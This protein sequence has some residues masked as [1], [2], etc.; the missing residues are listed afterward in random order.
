MAIN[1]KVMGIININ[2]DSYFAQ[3]RAIGNDAFCSRAEMLIEQGVDIIDIGACSTRPGSSYID[4]KE[5]W[6]RLGPVLKQYKNK[7]YNTP[8][9][10]DTFRSEIVERVYDFL[11]PFIVN[12]ISAGEDDLKML[13]SVG[14]IGLNYIA[15]HKRGT[16]NTM[17]GLCDYEDVVTDIIKYFKNFEKKAEDNGV[18][19][20]IIDPGFG[21]AKTVDQN[22]Q[23]L[24]RLSEFKVL[25]REILVGISRKSMI[26]CLLGITPEEA[27]PA[28]SALHLQALLSGA[29]ILRVHDVKEA[30]QS[31]A[32]FDRISYFCRG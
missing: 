23:M 29:N 25:N 5:E 6:K 2:D 19:N 12:D 11:G 28:T 14:N 9:S 20:F 8:L 24:A 26:Y 15:M 7:Y 21:F 22:Y 16:P 1:V 17:Q 10:I 4:K 30:K 31:V 27:L 32:L 13:A 18:I 3:S